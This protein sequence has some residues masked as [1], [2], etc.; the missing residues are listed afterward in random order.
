M[1]YTFLQHKL[2][3]ET[4]AARVD[5]GGQV[6]GICGPLTYRSIS[7]SLLPEYEYRE[8]G[9]ILADLNQHLDEFVPGLLS[10]AAVPE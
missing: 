4:W 9:A 1:R 3:R 2:S 5:D 8:D 10:D 7:N 6:A